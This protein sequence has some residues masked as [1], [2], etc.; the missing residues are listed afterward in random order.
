M[1]LGQTES[2][3]DSRKIG[4]AGDAALLQCHLDLIGHD[5]LLIRHL[6]GG[7]LQAAAIHDFLCALELRQGINGRL[8]HIMRVV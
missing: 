1:Q 3:E 6:F 5:L 7:R 4:V 8:D 2:L